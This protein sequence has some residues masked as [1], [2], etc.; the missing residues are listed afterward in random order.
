MPR[1]IVILEHHKREREKPQQGSERFRNL[2]L[3]L[4]GLISSVAIPSVGLWLG[5]IQK[6]KEVALANTQKNQEIE[7][8]Y[9][10]LGIR[11]LS[12]PPTPESEELR[13]WAVKLVNAHTKVLLDGKA[14]SSVV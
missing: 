6:D 7:K 14:A 8:G 4:A 9:V 2:A 11:I 1:R 10:E 12:D 3:G 13:K 5:Y